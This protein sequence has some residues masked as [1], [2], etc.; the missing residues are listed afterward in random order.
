MTRA[1]KN[2]KHNSNTRKRRSI[3][4]EYLAHKFL[5]GGGSLKTAYC[6]EDDDGV[7]ASTFA[8][9]RSPA[10]YKGAKCE[11]VYDP[12][13]EVGAVGISL[14]VLKPETGPVDAQLE[15]V[16]PQAGP[17]GFTLELYKPETGPVGVVLE[18]MK[19]VEGPVGTSLDVIKP[20]IGPV[21]AKA[22]K[23]GPDTGPVGILLNF[24]K[25]ENGPVG[26]SL[27][28]LKPNNGPAGV[29]LEVIKA[30]AGPVNISL[31]NLKPQEGPVGITLVQSPAIGPV[32]V[33]VTESPPA[34]G[35]VDT[36]LF[37]Y[38]QPVVSATDLHTIEWEPL[39]GVAGYNV[40]VYAWGSEYTAKGS[41]EGIYTNKHRESF[42]A[43]AWNAHLITQDYTSRPGGAEGTWYNYRPDINDLSHTKFRAH[44]FQSGSGFYGSDV[45]SVSTVASISNDDAGT[46]ED[47]VSFGT[48]PFSVY[49]VGAR[50]PD[51]Y[52]SLSE[53]FFAFRQTTENTINTLK[54]TN[55]FN[56]DYI[57][58]HGYAYYDQYDT[59]EQH[60]QYAWMTIQENRIRGLITDTG[61]MKE[62][63]VDSVGGDPVVTFP[64]SVTGLTETE[65]VSAFAKATPTLHY[66]IREYLEAFWSFVP[67]LS[68]TNSETGTTYTTA[69][70]QEVKDRVLAGMIY[71]DL[72]EKV[73][74]VETDLYV[75]DTLA[76]TVN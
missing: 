42:M 2:F 59:G 74:T 13:P 30:S 24:V 75:I 36:I 56:D 43:D 71:S 33:S 25:P 1:Y 22:Q 61:I 37:E 40:Y 50:Y 51:G 72:D 26:T 15:I 47:G 55:G 68:H 49:R 32:G 44:Q 66:S 57:K 8:L 12:P 10:V 31:E 6:D 20:E 14:E 11:M 64:G 58:T 19:P 76:N 53:P 21:G 45:T 52:V 18:S 46:F 3:S 60:P 65:H 62:I 23:L 27:S 5:R 28:A 73:F 39:D 48:I 7:V 63:Q 70:T 29:E 41:G 16:K 9:K 4:P 54:V 69:I 17:V 35:P 67:E 34:T 38:K